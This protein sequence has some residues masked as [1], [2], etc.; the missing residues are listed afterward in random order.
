MKITL[1]SQRK[2][3]KQQD[4]TQLDYS[5]HVGHVASGF[6]GEPVAAAGF[7]EEKAGERKNALADQM[8][9]LPLVASVQSKPHTQPLEFL[10]RWKFQSI[11]CGVTH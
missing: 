3:T 1:D 11:N 4:E 5:T 9:R 10:C 8:L 7:I 2:H 6:Q